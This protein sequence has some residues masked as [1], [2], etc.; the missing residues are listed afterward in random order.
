MYKLEGEMK[1]TY[2]LLFCMDDN[3]LLKWILWRDTDD[4]SGKATSKERPDNQ[5]SSG[6]YFLSCERVDHWMKELV[7]QKLLPVQIWFTAGKISSSNSQTS[8]EDFGHGSW[9]GY[10]VGCKFRMTLSHSPL[11]PL[12]S[13]H[14]YKSLLHRI[15][16][17][18]KMMDETDMYES[19]SHF[20]CSN[21]R[22]ALDIL[23]DQHALQ[24]IMAQQGIDSEEVF[25]WWLAEERDYLTKLQGQPVEETLQMEYFEKL[26][27]LF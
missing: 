23:Q 3:D 27:A 14:W 21:Y 11:G 19:L 20:L 26:V 12:A 15:I 5:D 24:H 17:Y 9:G 22:Q 16:S 8:T 1:L 4:G 2:C 10:D 6:D 18:F 13:E 7:G 25:H